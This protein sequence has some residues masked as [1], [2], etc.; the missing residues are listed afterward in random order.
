MQ[1]AD[2]QT[3]NDRLKELSEAL[4]GK[5]LSKASLTVWAGV[6][7]DYP[8]EV[9]CDAISYWAREKTKFPAPAEIAKVCAGRVSAN[10]ERKAAADK[11]DYAAGA[12]QIMGDPRIARA[13]LAKI[14]RILKPSADDIEYQREREAIAMQDIPV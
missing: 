2:L 6:L 7:K 8:I 13:H 1:R 14:R 4:N 12:R 11:A 9:I 10:L 3:L 5:Q